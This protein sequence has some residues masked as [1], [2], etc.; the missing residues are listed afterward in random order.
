MRLASSGPRIASMMDESS[1]LEGTVG[2]SVEGVAVDGVAFEAAQ[3]KSC[4]VRL[5]MLMK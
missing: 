5:S 3:S 2:V 4:F 1:L